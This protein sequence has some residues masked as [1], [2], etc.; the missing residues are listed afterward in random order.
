LKNCGFEAPVKAKVRMKLLFITGCL[1]PGKDGVGDYTRELATECARRGH[2]VFLISLNQQ[3]GVTLS[4]LVRF[5]DALDKN[6][7][8]ELIDRPAENRKACKSRSFFRAKRLA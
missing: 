6:I 8:I 5:A 2:A 7:R 1:E 4:T 3:P